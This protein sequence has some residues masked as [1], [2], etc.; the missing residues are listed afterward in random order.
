V[1][2]FFQAKSHR[3]VPIDACPVLA[4]QLNTLLVGCP[5]AAPVHTRHPTPICRTSKLTFVANSILPLDT[6]RVWVGLQ[7]GLQA[8]IGGSKHALHVLQMDLAVGI[9]LY[10]IVTLE[11]QRLNMIGNLV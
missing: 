2:G 9:G 3:V 5:R 1:T 7:A 8:A 11:K 10:P 6:W 4:P